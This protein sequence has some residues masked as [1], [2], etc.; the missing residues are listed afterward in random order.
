[1]ARTE[2][3]LQMYS[4]RDVTKDSMRKALE[5]VANMGYKYIEFAGF[6]DYNPEQIKSWLDTFGLVC[7]GTHTGMGAISPENIDGTIRYH[8]I[9]GCENLIVPGC[10]WSTPEKAQGVI[11]TLNFAQKKLAENGIRLGYHN[12]SKEFFPNKN[13]TIFE[14]EVIEKTS[15]ELEIDT[16]W[17][18]N[19]GI[20]PVPYLEAHKDRI[21]VIHLKDGDIPTEGTRD[22]ATA[23]DGVKG[24]SLGSGMAPVKAV[25]DWALANNVLMV[26]ESEGLDPTG[27]E[28]VKRCI[29]F[30]RSLEA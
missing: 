22:Y 17:L 30:L 27:P 8:K 9:I 5:D 26:V 19:A 13:G 20:D 12:H 28:E 16:F 18:F 14:N 6:F 15:V 29:D 11:D 1:M 2:Y 3:G 7:S 23:H 4:M 24:K 25:R 21:R 10:D